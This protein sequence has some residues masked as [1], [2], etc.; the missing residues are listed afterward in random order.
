[1]G[2]VLD[3][4]GRFVRSGLLA[5]AGG[6]GVAHGFSTRI[7][8]VS[9]GVFSS[10]SFGNPGDLDPARRD[11]PG[12]I[13]ANWELLRAAIGVGG[14]DLRG[15]E[16]VEV[17]QV[18]GD[19]IRV[20]HRGGASHDTPDGKDTCADALITD[21]PARLIAVRVA[22]CCPVLIASRDGH[23]VAAIHAGWRGVVKR[24][25]PL[26]VE[27]MVEQF[28]LRPRDLVAAIGPCIGGGAEGGSGAFEVGQDVA[29]E[30]TSVFGAGTPHVKKAAGR[31]AS[32]AAG[33]ES[34]FIV[35]M[36]GALREQL[37]ACG[38][39]PD[40]IEA[41][42]FCTVASADARGRPLFFSHRRDKGVTGRMVGIIG[43]R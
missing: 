24:I 29:A 32:E 7:G 3:A 9:G 40:S 33:H 8:G 6:I 27:A 19:A 23:T 15:R 39:T 5:D 18:H 17:H 11:P 14:D 10:L 36:Q 28:G 41:A 37:L 22:D 38:L 26:S 16:I 31:P 4:S 12:N 13:Q 34:K 42:P 25:V 43:P 1:M 2:C 20:V 30:F 21:D 35:D